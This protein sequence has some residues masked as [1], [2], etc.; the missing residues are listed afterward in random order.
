MN[1]GIPDG[2]WR[3]ASPPSQEPRS[4]RLSAR[5]RRAPTTGSPANP[6]TMNT[7]LDDVNTEIT[8][9]AAH[10][11]RKQVYVSEGTYPGLVTLVDGVSV[12]SSYSAA[13]AWQRSNAY[14]AIPSESSS[15]P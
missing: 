3:H 14:A 2:L 4:G 7:P 6:G 9:A 8:I 13:H 10:L 11:P 15:I 1:S 5:P 12:W